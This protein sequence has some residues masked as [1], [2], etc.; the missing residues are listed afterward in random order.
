[1]N[2]PENSTIPSVKVNKDYKEGNN[3]K[4][5]KEMLNKKRK[6]VQYDDDFL[7]DDE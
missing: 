7:V 5:D 3:L 2:I 6:K 4:T 1:L